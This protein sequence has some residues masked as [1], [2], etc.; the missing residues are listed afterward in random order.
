MNCWN[1]RPELILTWITHGRTV[2]I[3]KF[4]ELSDE[5]DNRPITCL[6]TRYKIFT[7]LFGK[8][9][10]DHAAR[11]EIWDKNQL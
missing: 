7:A 9:M 6:N 11:N 5:K 3:P 8:H 4:K 10:K 2:L 1:A